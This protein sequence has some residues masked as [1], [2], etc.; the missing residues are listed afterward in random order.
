MKRITGCLCASW[1]SAFAFGL[2]YFME[3]AYSFDYM[4]LSIRSASCQIPTRC[5]LSFGSRLVVVRSWRVAVSVP[6]VAAALRLV[7]PF[8]I[9]LLQGLSLILS[10]V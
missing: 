8:G 2:S 6:S 1:L 7:L 9:T 5:C 10:G 3:Q 4:S